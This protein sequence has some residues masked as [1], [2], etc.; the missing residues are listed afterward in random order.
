VIPF[1][2]A[3]YPT[4]A[5]SEALLLALVRGGADI[6][7]IGV[8]F[9]DPL[10]DGATVQRTSQAALQQGITLADAVAMVGRLRQEHGVTVPILLMGYVNPMLQYGLDQLATDSA[11]AGVDG[12]IVPDLPADE[13]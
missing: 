3:G 5:R 4:L 12:Y 10:A 2:T 6:V 7:E 9:S 1:I 11:A 8:P 13:S